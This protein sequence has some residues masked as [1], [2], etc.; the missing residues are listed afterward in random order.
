MRLPK[1]DFLN[2]FLKNE[3]TI[4]YIHKFMNL[5]FLMILNCYQNY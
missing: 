2:N 3:E 4:K 1:I 5:Q